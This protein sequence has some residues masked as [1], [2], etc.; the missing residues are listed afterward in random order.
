MSGALPTN[1]P[2]PTNFSRLSVAGVPTMGIGGLLPYTG[3][4]WFVDPLNGSDGN[5]GSASQPFQTL[6]HAQAAATAGQ[7]DVVVLNSTATNYLTSSLVWAK[8]QVHLIGVNSGQL[9]GKRSRIAP[10]DSLA[11]TAGFNDMVNVSA[12]NCLFMNIGTFF[13]FSNTAGA[14]VAWLDTGGR[15]HYVNCEFDGFGDGTAT[16]G[17]AALTGARSFVFNNSTGE[18]TW[19][20]CTFGVDTEPRTATNYNLEIAGGAPRLKFIGCDFNTYIGAGGAG[21]S[22][23]LIGAAGIDRYC[24]FRDCRFLNAVGSGATTMTQG[25]NLSGSAGGR[26]FITGATTISGATH[27]ETTQSGTLYGSVPLPVAADMG[28]ALEVNT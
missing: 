18:T 2:P 20:G 15:N 6:A 17:T 25:M 21:G 14:L 8:N 5:G 16:T 19:T 23:V 27:W 24:E 11:G 3:N 10:A 22:F 12:N 13:G 4:W 1:Y 7:N 26:V 28:L 9:I